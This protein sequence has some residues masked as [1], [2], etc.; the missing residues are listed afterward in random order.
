LETGGSRSARRVRAQ[1]SAGRHGRAAR[2]AVAIAAIAGICAGAFFLL[3]PRFID[4]KPQANSTAANSAPPS[5]TATGSQS[6]SATTLSITGNASSVRAIDMPNDVLPPNYQTETFSAEN[7]GTRAGFSIDMPE[8]W[9]VENPMGQKIYLDAPGGTT[10]VEIDLT[11]DVKS[12][13]VA[14]ADYLRSQRDYPGY[15]SKSAF[16]GAEPI[17]GTFGAFWR[18][19]WKGSGGQMR[20]DVLLFSLRSQSYTIY[21]NGSAGPGDSNWN[22]NILG[23]INK[24]LHTFKQLPA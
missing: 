21:A 24:M 5:A 16:I 20:M 9:H 14:E 12:N 2:A 10:Y 6:P 7:M 17:R 22:N 1:G 15:L 23:I 4:A 13:M 3:K 11:A 19:D 8:S 18:F